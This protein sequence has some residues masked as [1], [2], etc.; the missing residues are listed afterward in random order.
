MHSQINVN[1]NILNVFKLN[2][3]GT[4]KTRLLG[5]ALWMSP[6]NK[7]EKVE[8]VNFNRGNRERN[9]KGDVYCSSCFREYGLKC[10]S[11][12]SLWHFATSV[13]SLNTHF[14]RMQFFRFNKVRT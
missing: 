8:I 4:R 2:N 10:L 14:T 3:V 11:A 5:Y 13:N 7:H 9:N 1:L 12:M 6:E